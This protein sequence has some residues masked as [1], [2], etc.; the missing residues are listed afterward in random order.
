[1][2]IIEAHARTMVD[3]EKSNRRRLVEF[4]DGCRYG[5]FG[6][7]KAYELISQDRIRAYKMGGKTMIDLD[8]VDEYHASLPRVEARVN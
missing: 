4:K 1:M 3:N 2:E 5:K 8:S 7:T 6:R